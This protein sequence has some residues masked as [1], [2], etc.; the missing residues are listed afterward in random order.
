[1][2]RKFSFKILM[3]RKVS[4][5]LLLP[6]L[7][8]LFEFF[9]LTT[10]EASSYLYREPITITNSSGSTLSN[11]LIQFTINTYNLITTLGHMQ[12]AGQDIRFSR[13]DDFNDANWGVSCPYWIQT[14]TINT[15]T[16]SIWVKVD[17]IPTGTSTLYMYYGSSVSA[18]TSSS[19]SNGSDGNLTLTAT[20]YTDSVRTA[21]SS[22]ANAG[23]AVV[24][25][26]SVSGF[27][28]NQDVLLIQMTG[29]NVGGYEEG[30]I[31]SVGASSLTLTSNLANTYTV[32]GVSKAQVMKVPQYD[33]VAINSGGTLS[34]NA[35][36]GSTGG[37]LF[38]RANTITVNSGGTI[39]ASNTGYR[40][41]AMCN[42]GACPAYQGEGYNGPGAQAL[43]DNLG[44]GGG[45]A[46]AGGGGGGGYGGAG[47]DGGDYSGYPGGYSG[48]AY[49]SDF[50]GGSKLY[51]GAG[52]GGGGSGISYGTGGNGANGAGAIKIMAYTFTNSNSIT[53]VG[54]TGSVAGM[55]GGG[56]GGAG[57]SIFLNILS[58]TNTNSLNV[59]GGPGGSGAEGGAGGG[60]GRILF[61]YNSFSNSGTI[62]YGGGTAGAGSPAGTAGGAGSYTT[63]LNANPLPSGTLGSEVYCLVAPTNCT[64]S[65]PTSTTGLTIT[66]T[67]NAPGEQGFII[68]RSTDGTNYTW[69]TTV[70]PSS[71]VSATGGTITY[72][73]TGLTAN[74]QYWYRV[75]AY[76]TGLSNTGYATASPKYTLIETPSGISF[77]TV[78]INSIALSG[79]GTISNLTS[80][81]SGIYFRETATS[82]NSG[83]V[84][85][86][87]WTMSSLN[88][89]T[90]YTFYTKTRN[91]NSV[92]NAEVG[93]S[94]KYTLPVAPAATCNKTTSTWYPNGS[95]FTFTNT[96][97]PIFV[98][99]TLDHYHYIWDQNATQTQ[100][101][102]ETNGATW[103][104]STLTTTPT[105]DGS[106]YLHL[107]A[108]SGDSGANTTVLHLGPYYYDSLLPTITSY[109]LQGS[110]AHSQTYVNGMTTGAYADN[111]TVDAL[112]IFNDT[113]GSSPT[114]TGTLQV[115][116]SEDQS[117][118]GLY[119]GYFSNSGAGN[120][121]YKRSIAIT[122]STALQTNYQ[123]PVTPFTDS[124]FINNSGL[125]CSLHFS[126]GTGTPL[127]DMSG[128]GNNGTLDL[129]T[130]GN[131]S[132]TVAWTT[133]LFGNAISFDGTDDKVTLNKNLGT[134]PF[135]IELWSKSTMNT[136][137]K[138]GCNNLV[139]ATPRLYLAGN[140]M[141]YGTN[142]DYNAATLTITTGIS[143]Y[144]TWHQWVYMYD[145]TQ[146]SIYIDGAFKGSKT[147]SAENVSLNYLGATAGASNNFFSGLI[148]EVKIYNRALTAPEIAAR[149]NSG[150]PKVRPDYADIRF[151]NSS[152]VE[153][154]YW[155]ETDNKFW[156]NVD[157]I[158]TGTST[159]NMY[160]GNPSAT[161][162]SSY[163]NT[164]TSSTTSYSYNGD[165]GLIGEWRLE[166]GM[167][168]T[169][170]ADTSGIGNNGTIPS[171][172]W[173]A[174]KFGNGFSGN[175]SGNYVGF[176]SANSVLNLGSTFTLD[177]W[178]NQSTLN[179]TGPIISTRDVDSGVATK[180]Y[181]FG[182]NIS[183][184]TG[185]LANS[186]YFILGRN[187]WAWQMWCS[188][189]NSMT[190][191]WHHVVV[192]VTNATTT[193]SV[194]FYI[195]G[196]PLNSTLCYSPSSA[197]NYATNPG[198]FRIGSCY[199]VTL[200]SYET[201]YFN[202][203][204]DEV[205]IYNR[206]LTQPEI[207]AHY[208]GRKYVSSAPSAAAPQ[209]ESN[210][211]FST[212]GNLTSAGWTYYMTVTPSTGIQTIANAWRFATPDG[213]KNLYCRVR[214]GATN[215]GGTSITATGGTI[216]TF[217]N[218][219]VHTFN[220]SGTSFTITSGSG[221]LE[222]LVIGG[223]G[224]GGGSNPS[225]STSGGG[226]GGGLVYN[227]FFVG[228]PGAYSVT[229]GAGGTAGNSSSGGTGGS[230]SFSTITAA[231][232][233]GAALG[234]AGDNG[235]G[236]ASG[237]GT[238]KGANGGGN[239]GGAG[240]NGTPSTIYNGS[241]IY[242]GGGG[243]GGAGNI[244]GGAGGAGG[245]GAG[246]WDGHTAGYAGTANT[247][248]GG[249][250]SRN[251]G[252][253]GAGGSG[254]VIVRYLISSSVS[255]SIALDTGKP[256]DF[257]L[258]SPTSLTWTAAAQ[259]TFSWAASSDPLQN[260]YSSQM[261]SLGPYKLYING[262]FN[263]N[264]SGTSITPASAFTYGNNYTWS[265]EAYDNA[266]N[267]KATTSSFWTIE[268][269]KVN[270][271]QLDAIWRF[272]E[273]PTITWSVPSG[274][275]PNV[276]IKLSFDGGATYPRVLFSSTPNDGNQLYPLS[277]ADSIS[278]N[279]Q[280]R[281]SDSTQDDSAHS[282]LSDIFKTQGML[283]LS[284]PA[285]GVEWT[286]GT[287]QYINWR[288]DGPIDNVK[289]DY[290]RDGGATYSNSIE[291]T[292]TDY[293]TYPWTVPLS[294]CLAARIKVSDADRLEVYNTSV[295]NF[296]IKGVQLN[297]PNGNGT[298]T[299]G[300]AYN[301][302]WT[303]AGTIPNVKL[304]YSTDGGTNYN[305]VSG[306]GSVASS[307]L[308]YTWTVPGEA[309][310]NQIKVK[311]SD[312]LNPT[313]IYD[314]SNANF[315]IN[316]I[317]LTSPNG[318]E[319][320]E[321]GQAYPINWTTQ[322]TIGNIKLEYSTD[323]G[324]T[325]TGT[326]VASVASSLGT[327]SWTV[328]GAAIG[329]QVRIRASSLTTS[330]IQDSSDNYFT[331]GGLK[332]T[333]PNGTET[334]KVGTTYPITWSTQGTIT[335]IKLEYSIDNGANYSG[336]ILSSG[337]N[338]NTYSWTVPIAAMSNQAKIKI[339]SVNTPTITDDS[340]AS[341][342][343]K[344]VRVI[345]PNGA[346]MWTVSSQQNI[347]WT[348]TGT[349]S[350]ILLKYYNG[351]SWTVVQESE[352]TANDGI[353]VNDGSFSWTI[354]NAIG[355]DR[356]IRASDSTDSSVTD[357]SDNNFT[358]K[359]VLNLTLPD[360]G[361]SWNPGN[362]ETIS[363]TTTG[364][365]AN[366]KL[367]YS[368]DSGATYP[369]PDVI[370]ASLANTG[371][372]SWTIPNVG[373]T[374]VRVKV[375]DVN[376]MAI[377][378]A[379][380]GDLT[381]LGLGVISPNG[382]ET[383]TVGTSHDITWTW[384]GFA[385]PYSFV[386]KYST[387]SGTNYA[388]TI[389]ANTGLITGTY[390]WSIPDAVGSHL[391]IK[392]IQRGGSLNDDSNL[393]FTIMA[394]SITVI[395]P[396]A[397]A[398]WAVGEN[399]QISWTQ[400]VGTLISGGKLDISY[401]VNSTN[402][403]PATWNWTVNGTS[404]TPL[405]TDKP[406][407]TATSWTWT[408]IPA[409]AVGQYV[410]IKVEDRNSDGTVNSARTPQSRDYSDVFAIG[411]RVDSVTIPA[412]TDATTYVND[413]FSISWTNTGNIPAAN[414]EIYYYKEGSSSTLWT[415]AAAGTNP[416]NPF[417]WSVPDDITWTVNIRVRDS[418]VPNNANSYKDS[419]PFK[420][421]GHLTVNAPNGAEEWVVDET[422]HNITWTYR[423]TIGNVILKYSIDNFSSNTWTI[424]DAVSPYASAV[425]WTGAESS[426]GSLGSGYF[427][428]TIPDHVSGTV[429]VK[430]SAGSGATA[431]EDT[432][433]VNF[434]I[435]G[436]LQLSSPSGGETWTIGTNHSITW[437]PD[438]GTMAQ[439][440]LQFSSDG[441][442]WYDM[443][444][445]HINWSTIVNNNSPY[446]YSWTIPSA[447]T[448]STT[449]AQVRIR[450]AN[451]LSALVTSNNWTIAYPTIT[452]LHPNKTTSPTSD[453]YWI[454]ND[455]K[456]I[457]WT[458]I[459]ALK[460]NLAISYAV[461]QVENNN[462]ATW[463]VAWT[464]IATVPNTAITQSWTVPAAAPYTAI[465]I[466]DTD[467]GWSG[468]VIGY[469]PVFRFVTEPYI[470]ITLDLTD[471]DTSTP[472]VNDWRV[473]KIK[474][475]SWTSGYGV[476][477]GALVIK[478]AKDVNFTTSWTIASGQA[479]A[480]SFDWTVP[481]SLL[482][483][484]DGG[485][486]VYI[487]IIDSLR[488][489]TP[490]Y[491]AQASL[492]VNVIP[493]KITVG[494]IPVALT[495][496]NTPAITWALD[497]DIGDDNSGNLRLSYSSNGT[498]GTYK[499]PDTGESGYITVAASAGSYTWT[500]HD[501]ISSNCFFKIVDDTRST[502]TSALSN[503][504]RI[505]HGAAAV[506][507]PN[508]GQIWYS[509][510]TNRAITWTYLGNIGN[511]KLEY[512]TNNSTWTVIDGASSLSPSLG[513]SAWA[514][515]APDTAGNGTYTWPEI[516]DEIS[517]TVKVKI[518]AINSA[519][520]TSATS[521]SNFSI[522]GAFTVPN[523]PAKEEIWTLGDA[524]AITWTSTGTIPNVKIKYTI[525][526]INWTVI[527]G[528][529]DNNPSGE[530]TNWTWN[531]PI[532]ITPTNTATAKVRIES[533]DD[534]EIYKDSEGF[535]LVGKFTD[536]TVPSE[537]S[538]G[539]PA[540]IS[541]SNY[542][543]IAMVRLNYSTDNGATWRNMAG[544]LTTDG[545][546]AATI[547]S[548]ATNSY[549][550]TAPD[551]V[552]N[553]ADCLVKVA[554]NA[555]Y[556][557]VA[558]NS[559]SFKI[560]GRLSLI[561]PG[562]AANESYTIGNTTAVTWS[563]LGSTVSTAHLQY[564][565]DG[566]TNWK[567]MSGGSN[568]IY[569]SVTTAATPG[570]YS[571]T[572]TIP[573]DVSW[574]VKV[575][576]YDANNTDVSSVSTNNFAI[577]GTLRLSVS[578]QDAP[579]GGE[580]WPIGTQQAIKW[581]TTAGN[582]S[583][584]RVKIEY[585]PSDAIDWNTI[586][587]NEEGTAN[588]GIVAND[589][590]FTWTIPDAYSDTNA[591]LRVTEATG[592]S[593][594]VT[595]PS[596]FSITLPSF[597]NFNA[598]SGLIVWTISNTPVTALSFGDTY[599]LGWSTTGT[600][601]DLK[602]RYSRSSYF[603]DGQTKTII[604]SLTNAGSYNG[605][606]P[607]PSDVIINNAT[608]LA[609][610]TVDA[611]P[612]NDLDDANG[613]NFPINVWLRFTES[614]PPTP[615]PIISR[616][617]AETQTAMFQ[618][619]HPREIIVAKPTA[620]TDN[621]YM[622]TTQKIYFAKKGLVSS[623]NKFEFYAGS[624]IGWTTCELEGSGVEAI[625]LFGTNTV[626]TYNYV[627]WKIP[628]LL[629]QVSNDIT[630]AKVRITDLENTNTV[631][632]SEVFTLKVPKITVTR[633]NGGEV[634]A[635]NDLGSIAWTS[636]GG[637]SG[638]VAMYL[639]VQSGEPDTYN[640]A[641][642]SWTLGS[643]FA[644]T[645]GNYPD[646][647]TLRIEV[648]DNQRPASKDGSNADFSVLPAPKISGVTLKKY[649]IAT[650]SWT[651]SNDFMVNELGDNTE[652]MNIS[653]TYQGLN[654]GESKLTI[655]YFKDANNNGIYDAGEAKCTIAEGVP[656]SSTTDIITGDYSGIYNGSYTW[657]IPAEGA[658][659]STTG[660]LKLRVYDTD[661]IDTVNNYYLGYTSGYF[662]VRGGFNFTSPTS[663]TQW[664]ANTPAGSSNT[665]T[666]NNK[667][668]FPNVYL[669][670]TLDGGT[671]WKDIVSNKAVPVDAVT[672]KITDATNAKTI[673]N[674]GSYPWT[675]PDPGAASTDVMLKLS[676]ISDFNVWANSFT[677]QI[678]Y[679]TIKWHVMDVVNRGDLLNVTA[680]ALQAGTI[681]ATAT[682]NSP[683]IIQLPYGLYA[684]NFSKTAY[685]EL[686]TTEKQ[687]NAA[688]DLA[689]DSSLNNNIVWSSY[690]TS[691][692]EA[693]ADYHVFSN[694]AY[695]EVT[696]ML[697]VNTWLEKKGRLVL[698][699][700][701][702][703]LGSGSVAIYEGQTLLTTLSD[704][705]ADAN[706]NY[707]F[708]ASNVT[709]S[710]ANGGLG[711]TSGRTY[712]AKCSVNYGGTSGNEKTYFSGAS[713]DISIAQ[714]LKEMADSINA[715]SAQIFTQTKTITD[716]IVS[717]VELAVQP[718]V[719]SILTETG[720]ILTATG[721]TIPDAISA[722]KKEVV[723]EVK[724]QLQSGI[725]NRDTAVK[726]NALVVISYR[727]QPDVLLGVQPVISIY[728][729]LNKPYTNT[730]PADPRQVLR[731][732]MTPPIA[733]SD[734]WTYPVKFGQPGEYTI[735]C[736]EPKRGTADA[737][738]ISVFRQDVDSVAGQVSAIM[739]QTAGITGLKGVTDT[740]NTQFGLLES[741]LDKI[742][743]DIGN[744]VSEA[745]AAAGNLDAL[746]NQLI[747]ISSQIK[748]LGGTTG[749][750]L[751]SLYEVSVDKKND[752]TYLKN[753]TQELKATMDL[754]QKLLE[755]QNNKPVVESWYEFR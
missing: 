255:A 81:T 92:E 146:I 597:N 240:G 544:V 501:V 509:G 615:A 416:A 462:P 645:V 139:G 227:P 693:K 398:K 13:T 725:L 295:G 712:F 172:A 194:T 647:T 142:T 95:T 121:L 682:G 387:D 84:Q 390:A 429:K 128:N 648:R 493:P 449:Q 659:A 89:N 586:M 733:G 100:N 173:V 267:S 2:K 94:S 585:K 159:I 183:T 739:G 126:E 210:T 37:V 99:G 574:T 195:D 678:I 735:V 213:T 662:K 254:I 320:W 266:L 248:G 232:G 87:S 711:L 535:K 69:S 623:S 566:G 43:T 275:I 380:L 458:S 58:I 610:Y 571:Y 672:G 385:S 619:Y 217:G 72:V 23:Q 179:E 455:L 746:Y 378:D 481:Q 263:E 478:Y 594:T 211:S 352:G 653:W 443:A 47:G 114:G 21:I 697:K 199:T 349:I 548:N 703:A 508:G 18:I 40:L 50:T 671:T 212:I 238:G 169:T 580:N 471:D 143:D 418:R 365:I 1:M 675:V 579:I 557:S 124:T 744:K 324:A 163:A 376:S 191:G 399:Q 70:S 386:L 692:E 438:H 701:V 490:M 182:I 156:V 214:D 716:K 750:D 747:N 554:D 203:L 304:E 626:R 332:L 527:S 373:S 639:S 461:S 406:N 482:D 714:K 131:T 456:N 687:A 269:A 300:T 197:A 41:G 531:I 369:D 119:S 726:Q 341:F 164:D 683:L 565:N 468:N 76:K 526:G 321:V 302:Q 252:L 353:V 635:I 520:A 426:N 343:V 65:A 381:I 355:I 529:V 205:K 286:M 234:P 108:H 686:T 702:N 743:S 160:Y 53:S 496:G 731:L 272:G 734:V 582:A 224:G 392:V 592:L 137:P 148:D 708:D 206:A 663:A 446:T 372:Y 342:T 599:D 303:Y 103:T 606:Q 88:P 608:L 684:F 480:G 24:N 165:T 362:V 133:G 54:G 301:I 534:S 242:Y 371:S 93:P 281:I 595:S 322:G 607:Q 598:A 410:A 82:T 677:F 282:V 104:T 61:K 497:G 632:N 631:G 97:T 154:P 384:A 588:D 336:T 437:T 55:Y 209:A 741:A 313:I 306:A 230:S 464:P 704:I 136:V 709:K 577:K 185:R 500:V 657:T 96:N 634:W 140:A 420:I 494:S 356:K 469:S 679:Y 167:G 624:S 641:I 560:K 397:T 506:T 602:I 499:R 134:G 578:G 391:R 717:S 283:T 551:T 542:G 112:G 413:Q 127:A 685:V 401:A 476:N 379:S 231:G 616:S 207:V 422:N 730:N 425:G 113:G 393:D 459:G 14:G 145:G 276:R 345:T 382:G 147:L 752:L 524:R 270:N 51:L 293:D 360:G 465:K 721:T 177:A 451:D 328:P 357:D 584:T 33:T 138:H 569:T 28:V 738:V 486:P 106:W 7:I 130:G 646:V 673:P 444:D 403:D 487:K 539:V 715:V 251:N 408:N 567:N 513:G 363:W 512:S 246:G 642:A 749:L 8:F 423:G 11:F 245:G 440:K 347:T 658:L 593:N 118:W 612:L 22:T 370:V 445:Q 388:Y 700:D 327:Y 474:S 107:V 188:P 325:Y 515:S 552:N 742:S 532:N 561:T 651:V 279:C 125:V 510:D 633:P 68:E 339:S 374:H 144:T 507:S 178:V 394:P 415:I 720:R 66:W 311:V 348:T 247:G 340:D 523:P 472:F 530:P 116:F 4:G 229:V 617:A 166:E 264:A 727:A 181:G 428:W 695:D 649:D 516:P 16:T 289:L 517:N 153:L 215:V 622:G 470:Y 361:E 253:G 52:G 122:G 73:A 419:S 498:N 427:N 605:W 400:G 467:T 354:P 431:I 170:T 294:P 62:S 432:S 718:Q 268:V 691:E 31:Q 690:L 78:T 411:A 591:K 5:S 189:T 676:D 454:E 29:T 296:I 559:N 326:V 59:T 331:I 495:V 563:T 39:S 25:V 309:I 105:A 389:S 85:T 439:V 723:E 243:G 483:D 555:D 710:V 484:D 545:S 613:G 748:K 307:A 262:I 56:A 395:Q 745:T 284:D 627:E 123:V 316:G 150:T 661:N 664:I 654:S 448:S 396:D 15:T 198:A 621:W 460:G 573:D 630:N 528:S 522:R 652:K 220:S 600:V 323:N 549:S 409:A 417:V 351:T 640:T 329:A 91:G 249:G 525:N 475:I 492:N 736:Q 670:Y 64:I 171:A 368:T 17:S 504:F 219:K 628:S 135:S 572:W 609:Q 601:E 452:L 450:E 433:D 204:I 180:G 330:T 208:L 719:A 434:K 260:S 696:D 540:A 299:V 491:Q 755:S 590:S 722:V 174:G 412:L 706:G 583:L 740:I 102:I 201:T 278:D 79:S 737:I 407:N 705:S 152:G 277:G 297:S 479:N 435:F 581:S 287:L 405:L 665:I 538:V 629:G 556:T 101:Y 186:L 558:S 46:Y 466:E 688:N 236:G 12:S 680:K 141:S 660:D 519:L 237:G 611:N 441:S 547:V 161:S 728:D 436:H 698:S 298:W 668:T 503:N 575:K 614:Y 638:N 48:T 228:N 536:V 223:G 168:Y 636:E 67:D 149:Y 6:L 666:W 359:G 319:V 86:N 402:S 358:I 196:V 226:G 273:P 312:L 505:L 60:G 38:F 32:S 724:P 132:T 129:G 314:A 225:Y 383:W 291:V 553:T 644:W 753:K 310:G 404:L 176:S 261:W 109:S 596:F 457:Q 3:R 625:D 713:F 27:S 655:D 643:P 305:T 694:F 250:G 414:N 30:I 151:T 187:T 430:V 618:L 35:W 488:T 239:Q 45:G 120:W 49:G 620:A 350:N 98:A 292:T 541:W 333:S 485:Q 729:S 90:Q 20:A 732:D 377:E 603:A 589:G 318:G 184:T 442:N 338:N 190:T 546:Y 453:T 463:T 57:G 562:A 650:E 288:T 285:T 42:I 271:P 364:T 366:V 115:Q 193:P 222:V 308:S 543:N 290:S 707:W 335:P 265:I 521:A 63:S 637:V 421:K 80:G 375:S 158:P 218:Y 346:E 257:A 71:P 9:A 447:L 367:S 570:T 155:Q 110:V 564:S 344:G 26:S 74:T 111:Q 36:N 157:S 699:D 317:K 689:S 175:G 514:I 77:N 280:L 235:L 83:W 587:E 117:T 10:A 75:C 473:G 200:P 511:I 576:V 550:W 44:G 754:N 502:T 669:I 241:T 489:K 667:G 537:V 681:V 334:W 337:P 162:V 477:D 221:N 34:C 604:S 256:V 315:T 751:E 233:A 244:G 258:V 656:R 19:F 674:T 424:A 202:G 533:Y 192:T 568:P 518:T 216:T 259:P 274:D